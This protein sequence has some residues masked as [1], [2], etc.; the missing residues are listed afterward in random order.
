MRHDSSPSRAE[1]LR[2]P[3]P[4]W[5]SSDEIAPLLLFR[6]KIHF[7]FYGNRAGPP[8]RNPGHEYSRLQP[9]KFSI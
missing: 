7:A 8:K 4:S 1:P 9:S 6:N 5:P 3:D 2:A